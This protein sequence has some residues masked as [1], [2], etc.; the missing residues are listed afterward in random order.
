VGATV[1]LAVVRDKARRDVRIELT[2][3]D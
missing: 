2:T 3:V 1:A